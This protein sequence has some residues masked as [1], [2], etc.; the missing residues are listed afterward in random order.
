MPGSWRKVRTPNTPPA[1]APRRGDPT[2]PVH[3]YLFPSFRWGGT[4]TSA[5]TIRDRQ[6][7]E[8][9]SSASYYA[10]SEEPR[11]LRSGITAPV[12]RKSSRLVTIGGPLGLVLGMLL[13]ALAHNSTAP[14][15]R[16]ALPYIEP[17]G[18][19]W[20]NAL[21]VAVVP[22]TICL[23]VTGMCSV[24]RG[25]ELGKWGGRTFAWFLGLLLAGAMFSVAATQVYFSFNSPSLL[26]LPTAR[27]GVQAPPQGDW[28]EQ[29]VPTNAFA[30][31][32]SGDVLPLAV[33]S[34]LFGLA[35][36]SLGPERRRPVEQVF[37][38]VR[39]AV[40]VFVHW[41]LLAIP[42]GAFALTFTFAV[43]SGLE[44]AGTL[45]HFTTYILVLVF[46]AFLLMVVA[47]VVA[48]RKSVRNTLEA[49]SPLVA[50]AVGTRSSLASLPTLVESAKQLGLPDPASDIVLPTSVSVFKLN[51]T[52]TS[53]AKLLFI[54]AAFGIAVS[55]QALLVFI[56][57]VVL[58][59]F[60]TPGLPGGGSNATWGAYMAAGAPIEA[61]VLFEVTEPITD[62]A[63][64]ALNVVADFAVAVFVSRGLTRTRTAPSSIPLEASEE[65]AY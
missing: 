1:V 10:G 21:R 55:P 13:G 59:S 30:A 22:L 43:E 50:V 41:M 39:D 6:A 14:W 24:P 31:A 64:T 38:G 15:L 11:P 51:R 28:T 8:Q 25:G 44:T 42:L 46:V 54:G 57:T 12:G 17:V 65:P 27:P 48:A 5:S 3:D 20:M 36:R 60:A 4:K 45:V 58:L 37:V 47:T 35:L 23:L 9:R 62:V 63:K 61:I 32:A 34:V 33:L 40:L 2:P 26:E 18:K 56:G 52:I 49:L 7:T 29:L 16:E 53:T 19:L